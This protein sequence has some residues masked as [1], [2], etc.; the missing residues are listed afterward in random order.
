MAKKVNL[1]NKPHYTPWDSRIP[2]GYE[3]ARSTL[4]DS[5]ARKRTIIGD[6]YIAEFSL[7]FQGRIWVSKRRRE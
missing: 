1:R 4:M 3:T 7:D 5:W 6:D 2:D